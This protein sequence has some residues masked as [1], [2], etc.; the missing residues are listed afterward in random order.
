MTSSLM[1]F[2]FF[3]K[4]HNTRATSHK[5]T[6]GTEFCLQWK[7]LKIVLKRQFFEKGK[8]KTWKF[9]SLKVFLGWIDIKW[10]VLL[11]RLGSFFSLKIFWVFG[12][13]FSRVLKKRMGVTLPLNRPSS[14]PSLFFYFLLSLSFV[15][16]SQLS[17]FKKGEDWK[18]RKNQWKLDL[19]KRKCMRDAQILGNGKFLTKPYKCHA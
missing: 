15:L 9:W 13:F 5:E 1:L 18:S 19:K 3:L 16:L 11:F 7:Y 12:I 17:N 8:R 14:L 6:L 4:P 2:N 10:N